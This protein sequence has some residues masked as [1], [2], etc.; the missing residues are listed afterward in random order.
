MKF[1]SITGVEFVFVN[2]EVTLNVTNQQGDHHVNES[3]QESI[4]D[5]TLNS[6][7]TGGLK[8]VAIGVG[9]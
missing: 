7:G 4:T 9:S 3:N 8:D 2:C 6:N 1:K 5:V